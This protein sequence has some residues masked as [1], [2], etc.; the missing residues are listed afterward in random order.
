VQLLLL[1][2]LFR[3][4]FVVVSLLFCSSVRPCD[5]STDCNRAATSVRSVTSFRV[6]FVLLLFRCCFGSQ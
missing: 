5:L 6:A 2:F 3:C 1:L 4:C